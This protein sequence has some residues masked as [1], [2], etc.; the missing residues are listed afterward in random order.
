MFDECVDI[1]VWLCNG[2]HT[3]K[4]M[5][6]CKWYMFICMCM[7]ECAWASNRRSSVCFS[8]SVVIYIH[9]LKLGICKDIRALEWWVGVF[10]MRTRLCIGIC[11]CEY[12]YPYVYVWVYVTVYVHIWMYRWTYVCLCIYMYKCV[13]VFVY[14]SM[15]ICLL[16]RYVC[17]DS[18]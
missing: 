1:R 6:T 4:Y 2:K 7:S 10:I 18:T 13:Y 14:V 17:I 16:L 9:T 11:T 15:F 3:Y 12:M 8:D 5:F